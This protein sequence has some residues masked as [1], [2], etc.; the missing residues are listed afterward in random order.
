MRRIDCTSLL[1]RDRAIEQAVAAVQRHQLVVFATDTVYA[2]ACDAFSP[3][4]VDRLNKAKGR[5][6]DVAIPVMVGS[7]K[8]ARALTWEVSPAGGAL[9]E[10]F[11]PGHLT[12]VCRQQHTLKW[13]IG[14]EHKDVTLRMPLHPLALAVLQAVGPMAVVPASRAGEPAPLTC[15]AAQEQ[16]ADSVSVYLDTGDCEA[17][18]PSTV[19]DLTREPARLL[20]PGAISLELLRT[21][22]PD[23]E[24]ST[25]LQGEAP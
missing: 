25:E 6:S 10:G 23:L 7:I 5:L 19:V 17:L 3:G 11:W 22:D 15:A 20:R 1:G 16:L 12:V 18:L 21:V 24:A 9:M 2:V 8:A 4:G 14:G 13:D